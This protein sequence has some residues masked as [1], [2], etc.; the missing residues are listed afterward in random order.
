[1]RWMLKSPWVEVNVMLL[2]LILSFT[3]MAL[4]S[5]GAETEPGAM[6]GGETKV[7]GQSNW[8]RP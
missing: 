1:M 4:F 6:S 8:V 5:W 7:T 3:A 2:V